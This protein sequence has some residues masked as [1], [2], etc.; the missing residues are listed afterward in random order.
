MKLNKTNRFNFETILK[1]EPKKD[2]VS[3]E[4]TKEIVSEE[5]I[6]LFDNVAKLMFEKAIKNKELGFANQI[7]YEFLNKMPTQARSQINKFDLEEWSIYWTYKTQS[8]EYYASKYGIFYTH[9]DGN[10]VEHKLEFK[11]SA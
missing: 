9:V 7:Q 11:Y 5:D 2:K 6:Q 8:L 10:G 3:I 1:T 4:N